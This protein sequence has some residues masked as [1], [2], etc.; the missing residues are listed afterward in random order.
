MILRPIIFTG[1]VQGLFLALLLR[2]RKPKQ[3]ADRW[4]IS[5]LVLISIQLFFYF[6]NLSASPVTTGF[7]GITAFSV[8]LL[9][10]PA[11]FQYIYSISFGEVPDLKKTILYIFPWLAYLA[12][13]IGAGFIYP[14]EISIRYGY[15]HF[16]SDVPLTAVYAFTLPMAIVPGIY[17][18]MGLI[19]LQTYRKSL[20][21]RYSYTER[22]SLNWLK[23]LVISILVLFILLFLFIRFG[24]QQQI[25][26]NENLFAYVGAV[27]SLYVFIIGY[28][29]LRQESTTGTMGKKIPE[30]KREEPIPY[31]KTGLDEISAAQLYQR[32]L[33]HMEK[34]KPYLSDSLSL[35]MLAGQIGVNPNQLSQAINQKS[36][37]NFFVFVNTYRVQEVKTKLLD[38]S[39]SHLSI[40]GIAYECGFRSKSAFNRIFRAQTGMGP[41]EYQRENNPSR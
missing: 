10:A 23:W 37:N 8:P 28:M 7:L 27:L 33:E 19:V 22:I 15:P 21:D 1:A 32:L 13:T 25:V 35:S 4:L 36:A 30:E 11:L 34:E 29:G 14:N 39:L 26:S 41:L 12:L 6:D 9:T 18:I 31:Q 38:P 5:W 3:S 20:P 2:T 16:S 24:R 40:L 17:A